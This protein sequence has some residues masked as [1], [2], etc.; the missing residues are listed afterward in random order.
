MD[1]VRWT[2]YVGQCTVDIVRWTLYGGHRTLDT[3]RWTLYVGHVAT[4]PEAAL[5]VSI[6]NP[7]SEE[8]DSAQGRGSA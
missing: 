6:R 4:Y 1:I 3:V 5:N 2:L 8:Y 7:A